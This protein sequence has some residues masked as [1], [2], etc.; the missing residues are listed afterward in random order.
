MRTALA[1]CALGAVLLCVPGAASAASAPTKGPNARYALANGCYALRSSAVGR[2]VAKD[3]G[4]YT[5][6]AGSVGAGEPFYL[7]PTALGHYMLYG[8]ARD[9]L[10]A[11]PS[12]DVVSA[13]DSGES[14]NW[15][16]DVQGNSFRLTLP[17]AGNKAL[18]VGPGGMLVL[19]AAGPAAQFSME[20]TGGCSGFPESDIDVTGAPTRG[21]TPYTETSGYIDAHMHMMAFEFLG[22][23]AHCGR[24]WSPWGVEKALVD[25]PDH[26]VANGYGAALE[27]AISGGSPV[28]GHDPVGWPTFKD[29][30]AA[31]SLTHEDS[32]YR[33]LERS[34][35]AGQRIFVNLLVENK[36]LCEVY[37]LKQNS[38]DEEDA[39]RL[40]ARRI[41]ELENYIDA[42]S[43]GPGKGFFRIVTNPYDARRV[44]NDG[45][46]AIVLGIE[47]SEPFHCQVYNDQPRC[48]RGDITR[49]LSDYY[50]LGV[51]Q[52]EIVNKFD[53]A[54]AG[55][56]GD[57]GTTGAV[58]NQGNKLET[59]KYWQ[60]QAC[61]GP[62]D[63][64]DRQQ[65]GFYDHDHNDLF[66]NVLETALPVGLAPIYPT[67]AQ[68]NARGL[69]DL[70]EFAIRSMMGKKMIIDPD[71]LSVRARQSVMS[72]IEA[73]R[74]SGVISSHSW[75]TPDVIPRIYKLGGLI[76]PYAGDSTEFVRKWRETAPQALRSKY[77][78][79]F[80]YGADMN[81]FGH[82]G[83]PRP[84]GNVTYPFKSI[85]G[86]QTIDR[87]HAGSRVYDINKDGVAQYGLYPD[88]IQD[89]RKIAGDQ[90]VKDMSRGS[91]AYLQMWERADG[92]ANQACRSARGQFTARGM[93]RQR[94]GDD[95][96]ALL[97]RGGQPSQRSGRIYRYC[98]K[99]KGNKRSKSRMAAVFTPSGRVGLLVSNGLGHGT[100][101][102]T[103]HHKRVRI[104]H[105][106]PASRLHGRAKRIGKGLYVRRA[107]GG[108][109]IVY[110]VRRHRISYVGVAT[111]SVGHS[112][113]KL[114]A[115]LRLSGVH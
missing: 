71:H 112:K 54:L 1:L 11:N 64:A 62:A 10:A 75:S 101:S 76:T 70:G 28:R 108:R 21:S 68:C 7:K 86:K 30:P 38:C 6:S 33:W 8:R 99:S 5:A 80:G 106:A 19:A 85:D 95:P 98:V 31:A 107:R 42:Q 29:W 102:R 24:P 100:I 3:G 34:W 73:Q 67:D 78:Y 104:S 22:G 66:S 9:Y 43:G 69:T 65:V 18:T 111:K 2:T 96:V 94:L 82:Q 25:C 13:P 88:W 83:N 41:R 48:D 40:Q 92:V 52:M 26:Y 55:V 58:V 90:I 17:S 114:R 110:G 93:G 87:Q 79:G 32:Y 74:Y 59:G 4:G 105:G 23:R 15:T 81:G 77:Y 89:L 84:G 63:E 47:V 91:E 97:K 61:N 57:N 35:R 115:Y 49:N 14:A 51:R 60:M 56:A 72:L 37:P 12:G 16:I 109:R 39:I 53:N 45:K 46:L 113:K 20:G 44:I 50:N 36:V 103:R 27:N